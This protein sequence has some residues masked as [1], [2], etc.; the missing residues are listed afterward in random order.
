MFLVEF[1]P[2][3]LLTTPATHIARDLKVKAEDMDGGRVFGLVD[4]VT[5]G[6]QHWSV[7]VV[8]GGNILQSQALI[9][10]RGETTRWPL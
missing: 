8:T 7:R 1:I 6:A 3:K 5:D 10:L 9:R 2:D 4:F